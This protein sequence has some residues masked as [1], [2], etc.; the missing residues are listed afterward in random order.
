[1]S[2]RI[3][4]LR[5]KRMNYVLIMFH[6]CFIAFYVFGS[7]LSTENSLLNRG[8][9]SHFSSSLLCLIVAKRLLPSLWIVTYRLLRRETRIVGT[10]ELANF[11][12]IS[13]LQKSTTSGK[14]GFNRVHAVGCACVL[15]IA[16]FRCLLLEILK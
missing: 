10:F 15:P 13:R 4:G 6:L 9:H 3:K 14:H 16:W 7:K 5:N 1:M 12:T 8:I 2:H 11:F